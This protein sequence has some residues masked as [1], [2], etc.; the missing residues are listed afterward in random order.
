MGA[1]YG[2]LK[3]RGKSRQDLQRAPRACVEAGSEERKTGAE[4]PS[5][6]FHI[7]KLG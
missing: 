5:L 6:S 3:G 4:T 1:V 2:K 7:C